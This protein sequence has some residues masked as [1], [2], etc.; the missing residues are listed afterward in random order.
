LRT[1]SAIT[2]RRPFTILGLLLA[3]LVIVA[4]VLVALNASVSGT[5][6]EQ[7][8]V[9]ATRD[10]QPRVPITADALAT[11]KVPIPAT[12]QGPNGTYPSVY[13]NRASDVVGMVPLVAIG[14]GQAI[15]SN[16]VAK[17]NQAAGPQSEYLPIPHGYV[18][19]T[20]PT[21][22][23]QGVADYIQAGDYISVIATVSSAG[24]VASKTIFT[25]LHVIKIGTQTSTSGASATSLTVVV[26]Q[27]QAEVITWFLTYA[28]LKYTLE[29]YHDYSP[30]E[31]APD[32]KCPSVGDAQG[33]TLKT[34]Q[35]NFPGLF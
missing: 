25:Q 11:Q 19:L 17:A 26:T 29:S 12:G 28:A 22:E 6:L 7:T 13:F 24:K 5:S 32:P 16:E 33:V 15:T 30:G 27:C 20:V 4:F 10:L 9:V 2:S 1:F 18:A 14:R 21:S 23:Q 8:A 31:Q 35:A 3:I 34:I